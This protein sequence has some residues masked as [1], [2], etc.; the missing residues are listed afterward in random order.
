MTICTVMTTV[1]ISLR[2]DPSR[3]Q[4]PIAQ[5]PEGTA[6]NATQKTADG[7]WWLVTYKAMDGDKEGW[8]GNAGVFPASAC[9]SL[10]A[11]TMTPVP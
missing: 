6:L 8:I 9:A 11:I 3:T 1:S 2:P 10:P 4:P 5:I 7:S